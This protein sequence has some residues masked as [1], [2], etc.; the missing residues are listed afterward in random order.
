[1]KPTNPETSRQLSREFYFQSLSSK[2]YPDEIVSLIETFPINCDY[3]Q[4]AEA[5]ASTR[6]TIST[7]N[8]PQRQCRNIPTTLKPT[9]SIEVM[10]RKIPQNVHNKTKKRLPS[11]GRGY[12][13]IPSSSKSQ[14]TKNENKSARRMARTGFPCRPSRQTRARSSLRTRRWAVQI[15]LLPKTSLKGHLE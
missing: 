11:L 6:P 8:C 7:K 2:S 1:M 10:A 4:P 14:P 13:A 9:I 3:I 5:H 15:T 12:S